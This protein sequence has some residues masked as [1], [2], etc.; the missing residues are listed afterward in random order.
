MLKIYDCSNSIKRPNHRGGGGPVQNDVIAQLKKWG[1]SYEALFVNYIKGADVILT[2]DV[3]T[4][5]ALQSNKPKLKRMDGMFYR[6]N[7]MYRNERYNQAALEADKVVFISEY[8]KASFDGMFGYDIDSYV[9][10]NAADPFVFKNEHYDKSGDNFIAACTDWNREE[11]R[12]SSIIKLAGLNSFKGTIYLIGRCDN[13]LPSNIKSLGYKNQSEMSDIFN[14]MDAFINFSYR[15]PA[16]K[17]VCQAL[18][19]GLP[20]FYANSGGVQESVLDCGFGIRDTQILDLEENAPELNIYNTDWEEF[21]L[22]MD[23]Y[24]NSLET[25]DFQRE[26]FDMLN[27][28]F[29]QMH[30]LV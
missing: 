17:V 20:I 7:D 27:I 26:F 28:Y 24:K 13:V 12:L 9:A 11:K 1:H 18:A 2:N 3:F 16:P 5:E 25:R 30:K 8:A 21:I 14:H 19:A 15:D 23:T 22:R 29:T 6:P 10:L 4:E